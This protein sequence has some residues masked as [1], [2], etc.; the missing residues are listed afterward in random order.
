M[1]C[2]S[3]SYFGVSR[4][5]LVWDL[6]LRLVYFFRVWVGLGFGLI[7]GNVWAK[8]DFWLT[9]KVLPHYAISYVLPIHLIEKIS[10]H[11]LANHKQ[12]VSPLC[13]VWKKKHFHKFQNNIGL[14]YFGFFLQNI[15]QNV[16]K[17]IQN[18]FKAKYAIFENS[19]ET[20]AKSLLWS[21]EPFPE[22]VGNKKFDHEKKIGMVLVHTY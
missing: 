1:S 22:K 16:C 20:S 4:I 12:T 21:S 17:I 10:N 8:I 7:L 15:C 3:K 11:N 19:Y 14:F 6:G 13:V 2:W 18:D 5:W 9:C